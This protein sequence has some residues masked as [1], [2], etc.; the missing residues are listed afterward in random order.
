MYAPKCLG[1]IF[2]ALHQLQFCLLCELCACMSFSIGKPSPT[3][4]DQF[5]EKFQIVVLKLNS[6]SLFQSTFFSRDNQSL[7]PTLPR[8]QRR[9]GSWRWRSGRSGR[10]GWSWWLTRAREVAV[11]I[12]QASSSRNWSSLGLCFWF[13]KLK[14][15]KPNTETAMLSSCDFQDIAKPVSRANYIKGKFCHEITINS[16]EERRI[17]PEDSSETHLW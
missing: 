5:V 15:N 2:S 10:P 14:E 4:T 11:V 9:S 3:K 6:P 17:F 12:R 13:V 1:F 8:T 16:Q 7:Q